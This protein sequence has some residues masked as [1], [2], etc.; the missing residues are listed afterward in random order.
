MSRR[1]LLKKALTSRKS[2]RFA[3]AVALAEALGFHLARVSGVTTY[4]FT[5]RCPSC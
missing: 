3:E 1:D 5:P 4:S 2:L